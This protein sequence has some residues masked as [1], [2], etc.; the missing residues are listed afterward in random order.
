MNIYLYNFYTINITYIT[1]K[2][3]SHVILCIWYTDFSL[4]MLI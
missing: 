1:I 3:Y 2:N 4:L